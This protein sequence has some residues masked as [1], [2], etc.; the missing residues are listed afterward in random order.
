MVFGALVTPTYRS[1]IYDIVLGELEGGHLVL[2]RRRDQ[3][4]ES[5]V[6]V[7]ERKLM[8]ILRFLGV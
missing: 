2:E 4:T 7:F 8:V 5:Q 3:S 6:K 1:Y